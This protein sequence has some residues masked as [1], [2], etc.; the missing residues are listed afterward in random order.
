MTDSQANKV[1]VVI[2]T[3]NASGYLQRCITSIQRQRFPK[4]DLEIL[5]VDGGSTDPTVELAESLGAR[6]VH[7]PLRTNEAARAIGLREAS[8]ELVVLLDADNELIGEDWL[9]RMLVPFEDERV[10]A[11]EGLYWAVDRPD[12]SALDRYCALL[13]MHD[14]LSLFLGNYSHHSYLTGRWTDLPIQW[15]DRP[16]YLEIQPPEV[17]G[18]EVLPTL[19]SNGCILRRRV[20]VERLNGPFLFDCDFIQ[21]LW[22][23]TELRIARAPAAVAHYHSKSLRRFV[24]KSE[25][26]IE[27]YFY[28]RSRGERS[29]PYSHMNLRK[30]LKFTAASLLIVPTL[31]QAMR[32]YAKKRDLAWFLHPICCLT[33]LWTYGRETVRMALPW[34]APRLF[35]RE[36]IRSDYGFPKS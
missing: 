10:V 2:G 19:G 33:T 6:V 21:Q 27:D 22:E 1:S 26:T 4:D 34:S 5:V 13:G 17:P 16:G 28:Y 11:C 18:S 20:A 8:G 35:D 25:R 30:M 23:D 7:N 12:L 24:L 36:R 15:T 32:G 29:Y 14:P 3:L 9:E 31:L